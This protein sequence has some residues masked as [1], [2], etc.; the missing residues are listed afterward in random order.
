MTVEEQE[1]IVLVIQIFHVLL[2][3][4]KISIPF[5]GE[6]YSFTLPQSNPFERIQTHN[7]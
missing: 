2:D 5:I 6:S 4:L 3:E 1:N 7:P